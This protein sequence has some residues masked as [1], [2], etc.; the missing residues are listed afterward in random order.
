MDGQLRL[1]DCGARESIHM[2]GPLRQVINLSDVPIRIEGWFEQVNSWAT[3]VPH[4]AAASVHTPFAAAL[5]VP[6]STIVRSVGVDGTA[7]TIFGAVGD[8]ITPV[9]RELPGL[10]QR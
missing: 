4:V 9:Q 7:L 8:G 6:K 10:T 1:P 3:L 2:C 5:W